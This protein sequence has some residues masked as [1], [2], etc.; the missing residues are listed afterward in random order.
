VGPKKA[1]QIIYSGKMYSAEEAFNL[2]LVDRIASEDEFDAVVLESALDFAGKDTP[3]FA[4]IKK[5]LKN[6]TLNT[7]VSFEMETMSEFVDVWYSDST[8]EQLAKIEIRS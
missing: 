1:E 2:N 8:R 7:I 6:E 5:M 3:A 4:S